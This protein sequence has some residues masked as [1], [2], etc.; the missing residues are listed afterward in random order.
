MGSGSAERARRLCKD[1]YQC[2]L[3]Q[4]RK[5]VLQPMRFDFFHKPD[6]I[7]FLGLTG[8]LSDPREWLSAAGF[9]AK[10]LPV[11][12]KGGI[13]VKQNERGSP[14]ETKSPF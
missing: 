2:P 13:H 12:C 14:G 7:S 4:L 3:R 6:S 8:R 5:P 9:S 10:Y 1:A 11:Y